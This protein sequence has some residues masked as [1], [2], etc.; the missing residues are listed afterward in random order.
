LTPKLLPLVLALAVLAAGEAQAAPPAVKAAA[1]QAATRPAPSQ[2]PP[3]PAAPSPSPEMAQ[4]F[5][6]TIIAQGGT[7]LGVGEIQW[8]K[9]PPPGRVYRGAGYDCHQDCP[10]QRRATAQVLSASSTAVCG[11][12]FNVFVK[13]EQYSDYDAN[14]GINHGTEYA[15]P[16]Q[17]Q[18]NVGV[19]WKKVTKI[20]V[21][22][23]SVTLVGFRYTTSDLQ[24]T[25]PTS[26]LAQ[27][28]SRAMEV[29][30]SHCDPTT[31]Y[32]F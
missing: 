12:T 9:T 10:I 25:F 29:L 17:G 6:K 4:G 32:G 15:R 26:E 22:Y 18:F 31:S 20:G 7:S 8:L 30:R 3:P 24:F 16:S 27:R 28:V 1:S 5:I 19:D 23:S 11:T 14:T 21:S 13:G 2:A